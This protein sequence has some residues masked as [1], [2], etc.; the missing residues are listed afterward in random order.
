[1]KHLE[2]K[3]P[4]SDLAPFANQTTLLRYQSIGESGVPI[5]SEPISLTIN[6]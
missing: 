6:R 5:S 1:M 2:V 3:V 4:K